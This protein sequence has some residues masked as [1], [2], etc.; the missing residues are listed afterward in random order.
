MSYGLIFVC[1]IV[2][3]EARV[4]ERDNDILREEVG[5]LQQQ[6]EQRGSA[7][8]SE[9]AALR[10]QVKELQLQLQQNECKRSATPTIKPVIGQ[11]FD[12][13]Y[14]ADEVNLELP[15]YVAHA[16]TQLPSGQGLLELIMRAVSFYMYGYA[17]RYLVLFLN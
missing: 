9:N 11:R 12:E 4:R 14:V 2:Q 3:T 17:L 5:E 10:E 6:L 8:A 7:D 13:Q 15:Q 16:V 1:F